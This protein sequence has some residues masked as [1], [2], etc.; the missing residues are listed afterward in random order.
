MYDYVYEKH[1]NQQVREGETARYMNV[2]WF[3]YIRK[4]RYECMTEPNKVITNKANLH[5]R[6][7]LEIEIYSDHDLISI[8]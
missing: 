2:D 8:C 6:S 5:T 4:K 3:L 7:L 1:I